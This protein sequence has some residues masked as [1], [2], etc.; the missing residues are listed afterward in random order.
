MELLTP[1]E[2]CGG[3][4]VSGRRLARMVATGSSFSIEVEGAEYFPPLLADPSVD[5]KHL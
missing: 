5:R 4:G 3:L 2:F 1:H